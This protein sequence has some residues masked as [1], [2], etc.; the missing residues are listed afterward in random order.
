MVDLGLG[1]AARELKTLKPRL[2]T[3]LTHRTYHKSFGAADD[4]QNNKVL[5]TAHA[6]IEKFENSLAAGLSRLSALQTV[7]TYN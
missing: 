4:V 2:T 3:R 1:Y 6:A 5:K 7:S